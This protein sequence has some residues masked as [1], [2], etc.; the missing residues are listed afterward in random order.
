[1]ITIDVQKAAL[2][3]DY[4]EAL[5]AGM[6]NTAQCSF[7]FSNH[8]NSL[9]R[10]VVFTDGTVTINTIL[11]GDTCTV[12]HEVLTVPGA[13]VMVG[14][15]GTDGETVVLPTVWGTLGIVQ[16]GA[17]PTGEESAEPTLPLWIQILGMIGSLDELTT[18]DKT[19]LV[20]AINEAAVSGGTGS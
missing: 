10:T 14:V 15:Y 4:R 2:E 20:S 6:A 17:D 11:N 5:T 1:M 13:I 16:E 18:E 9:D 8:W 7:S 3:I 12:P 19:D